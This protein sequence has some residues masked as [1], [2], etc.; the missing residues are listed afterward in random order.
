MPAAFSVDRRTKLARGERDLIARLADSDRLVYTPHQ[1]DEFFRAMREAKIYARQTAYEDFLAFAIRRGHLNQIA[2]HAPQYDNVILRFSK[3]RATPL[4][5][6]ASLRPTGYFSHGTA[7]YLNGLRPNPPTALFLNVEQS[8]KPK[9]SANSLT[10]ASLERAF[11]GKQRQSQLFYTYETLTVTMLSGKH[12]GKLGVES[13]LAANGRSFSATN[14]ERTLVD[15]TVRP[16]Y[17]GGINAVLECYRLAKE[18]A[19]IQK[20]L[21]ILDELDYVYPYAQAIGF[22]CQRAGFPD[23]D[24]RPL[25]GRITSLKFYLTHG[26]KSP[27]FD[28]TWQIYYPT[29]L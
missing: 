18:R 2:F 17:A 27:A 16:A 12:S 20:A 14:L 10:Q 25:R 1:L 23:A 15:L 13:I 3:A 5:L 22:L 9:P 6:A 21:Q 29:D 7:A 11:S 28:E 26:M 4:D 19:S 24:L 8:Q